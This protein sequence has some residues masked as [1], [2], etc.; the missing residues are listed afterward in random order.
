MKIAIWVIVVAAAVLAGAFWLS[1]AAEN[2]NGEIVI[3]PP[4]PPE[5]REVA[6]AMTKNGFMPDRV[7]IRKGEGKGPEALARPEFLDEG[8]H[9]G[10]RLTRRDAHAPVARR[11]ERGCI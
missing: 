10:Q 4:P 5:A 2:G 9:V 1:R 11:V 8:A 3:P 6:V 7:N